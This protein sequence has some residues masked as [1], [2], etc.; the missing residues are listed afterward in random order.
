MWKVSELFWSGD[1]DTWKK[2]SGLCFPMQVMTF[3]A[4]S[5]IID[6]LFNRLTYLSVW[7]ENCS[8]SDLGLSLTCIWQL[9]YHNSVFLVQDFIPSVM[10]LIDCVISSSRPGGGGLGFLVSAHWPRSSMN[11]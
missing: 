6:I 4:P 1:A 7:L 3:R 8:I 5:C 2:D 11:L 9:K 10:F